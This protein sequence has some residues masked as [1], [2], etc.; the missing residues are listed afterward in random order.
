M[1]LWVQS[2]EGEGS[3]F[4]FTIRMQK[5]DTTSF[6]EALKD[7]KQGV[8]AAIDKL[9]RKRVLLV[10]DN[11][12]NQ[13]LAIDLLEAK[14]LIVILAENGQEALD[15]LQS[16]EFDL[17]LMDIQM[18]VMD[19]YEA[20]R[21]IREQDRFKDL[22]VLSMTANVMSGDRD[23][24]REVG[25]DDTIAKPIVPQDMFITMAKWV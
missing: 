13:E 12:M 15:I 6:A 20:T 5:S 22:P 21:K 25:M 2:I 17:V 3:T 1:N 7:T 24:A 4:S 10:E 18:P 11:D 16:K 23:K 8:K 14:G 9:Y 19:G